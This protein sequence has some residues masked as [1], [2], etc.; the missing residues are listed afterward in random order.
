[1]KER[2]EKKA[3]GKWQNQSGFDKT[4]RVKIRRLS[5]V[6]RSTKNDDRIFPVFLNHNGEHDTRK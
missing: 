5:K 4:S 1:M 2:L 3:G 6:K